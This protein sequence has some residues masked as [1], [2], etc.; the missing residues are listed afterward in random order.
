MYARGVQGRE[1]TF[2][3]SGRLWRDNLVMY[4]RQTNSW[5]AQATGG[6]IRG[7]MKGASLEQ[8][9]SFMMTWRQWRELHPHTTVLSKTTSLGSAGTRDRYPDYHRSSRIGVTGRTR[10]KKDEIGPKARVAAFRLS[11]SAYA[12]VL[13]DLRKDPVL[14]ATAMGQNI[15]IVATAD[16]STARAFLADKHLFT[17]SGSENG[18]I[19]LTDQRTGSRWDGFDG[20]AISGT[21]AGQQLREAPVTLSYWFAWKAF[22]PATDV[23]RR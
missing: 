12:V 15:V 17:S 21:L 1:L 3:V 22:F 11:E 23:L 13:D 16:R 20:R 5:W 18:R 14:N 9:P 10:F 4:D 8:F 7:K 19:M 2:G 6:A